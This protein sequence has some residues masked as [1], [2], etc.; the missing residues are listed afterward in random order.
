MTSR[1]HIQENQN[2]NK[3][4]LKK[5]KGLFEGVVSGMGKGIDGV[6]SL[7]EIDKKKEEKKEGGDAGK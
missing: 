1:V 6:K 2:H 5:H 3:I 4:R 7:M